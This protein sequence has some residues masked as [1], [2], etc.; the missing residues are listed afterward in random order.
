[1][2]QNYRCTSDLAVL[3]EESDLYLVAASYG[4]FPQSLFTFAT[5]KLNRVVL[6]QIIGKEAYLMNLGYSVLCILGCIC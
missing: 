1:M 2:I 3:N 6:Q 5:S 4:E